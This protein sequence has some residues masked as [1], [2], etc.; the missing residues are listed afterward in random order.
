MSRAIAIVGAPSSI[1]IRPYDDGMARYLDRAP[2]VLRERGLAARLR[3][4]DMGDVGP[5]PYRDY[6]RPPHR[7]RNEEQVIAYSR[8]IAERV[9]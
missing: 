9:G 7:P 2:G 4:I 3:A 5:P 1:G 6:E 8:A